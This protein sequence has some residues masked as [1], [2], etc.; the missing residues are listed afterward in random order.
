MENDG[1]LPVKAANCQRIFFGTRSIWRNPKES[2]VISSSPSTDVA[3]SAHALQLDRFKR[4]KTR[5]VEMESDG[6]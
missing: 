2:E 3:K 5:H 4:S 1:F 6:K